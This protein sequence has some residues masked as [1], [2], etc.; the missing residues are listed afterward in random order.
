[1]WCEAGPLSS[2]G[3]RLCLLRARTGVKYVLV[4]AFSVSLVFDHGGRTNRV[5]HICGVCGL[6]YKCFHLMSSD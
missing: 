1:M 5:G 4:H 6:E 2:R 3:D